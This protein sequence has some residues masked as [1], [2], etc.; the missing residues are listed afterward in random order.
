MVK[1]KEL[2]KRSWVQER[3]VTS[4]FG[5]PSP[6]ASEK[7]WLRNVAFAGYMGG[8]VLLQES[9]V[10]EFDAPDEQG[11]ITA[12][13]PRLAQLVTEHVAEEEEA[14]RE[15]DGATMEL[16]G[17]VSLSA[18]MADTEEL[19]GGGITASLPAMADL[20]QELANDNIHTHMDGVDD[21]D[22]QAIEQGA[23][24]EL[25]MNLGDA[26]RSSGVAAGTEQQQLTEGLGD[27][28]A[29]VPN[30]TDLLAGAAEAEADTTEGMDLTTG[31]LPTLQ[32]RA[33][34]GCLKSALVH[35]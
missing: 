22:E 3:I 15:E 18:A 25:T 20:L 23:E 8:I 9:N 27:V 7:L 4:S 31:Q 34:A 10:D 11:G 19:H 1:T 2:K 17:T 35:A 24:M 5:R 13:L 12:S 28:T 30:L 6:R 33:R 21:A 16:T 32:V 14:P 26:F 29:A